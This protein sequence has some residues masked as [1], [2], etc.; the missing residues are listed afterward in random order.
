MNMDDVVASGLV[1]DASKYHRNKKREWGIL[2]LLGDRL[3]F[4]GNEGEE[5]EIPIKRIDVVGKT[6][7]GNYEHAFE[8]TTRDSLYKFIVGTTRDEVNKIF[9]WNEEQS[10]NMIWNQFYKLKSTKDGDEDT[11]E[12]VE[13]KPIEEIIDS[14]LEGIEELSTEEFKLV[15]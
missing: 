5:L 14:D 6:V 1:M 10:I 9:R 2:F 8:I 13:V 4:E 15:E 7:V 3:I 11:W 12:E